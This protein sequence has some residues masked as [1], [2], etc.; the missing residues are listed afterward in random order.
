M[1]IATMTRTAAEV[2][3]AL[4]AVHVNGTHDEDV[5]PLAQEAHFFWEAP[6]GSTLRVFACLALMD[7]TC[8]LTID[9]RDR[10]E[11]TVDTFG[12]VAADEDLT[13]ATIAAHIARAVA[14]ATV[15][16]PIAF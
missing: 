8:G 11:E 16:R 7:G 14:L 6:I 12:A 13:A 4:N 9:V 5:A 1:N 15:G 2:T 10:H 3:D